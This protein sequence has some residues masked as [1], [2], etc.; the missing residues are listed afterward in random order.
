MLQMVCFGLVS[1]AALAQTGFWLVAA[2]R[3]REWRSTALSFVVD[4]AA[5]SFA[6]VTAFLITCLANFRPMDLMH[7]MPIAMPMVVGALAV[8]VIVHFLWLRRSL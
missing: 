6:V 1:V 8:S 5:I 7:V 2:F 4:R 3:R